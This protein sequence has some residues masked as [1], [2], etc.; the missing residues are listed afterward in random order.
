MPNPILQSYEAMMKSFG[1]ELKAAELVHFSDT[2]IM[3][4]IVWVEA[5]NMKA[6]AESF[7]RSS[8]IAHLEAEVARIEFLEVKDGSSSFRVAHNTALFAVLVPMKEALL[9][10]KKMG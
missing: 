3:D 5:K 10:L 9:E 7:L 4:N 1:K 6:F 8:F 2:E